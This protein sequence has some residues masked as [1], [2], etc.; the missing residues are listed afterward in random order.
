MAKDSSHKLHKK[1]P[2]P[3]SEGFQLERQQE[4]QQFRALILA[5]PNYFGNLKESTFQPV[6]TIRGSTFYEEIGCVGFQPQFNRLEAVIYVKQPSGYGGG[7][8]SDGTPEH[9]RFYLSYDGGA[10]WEDQG[11]SR[12]TAYDIPEGTEGRKRLEY[13]VSHEVHPPKK[14]CVFHNMVLARAILSWNLEPPPGDP[15]FEPVWGDIHNTHILVDPLKFVLFKDFLQATELE[16]SAQVLELID[17]LQELSLAES[18]PLEFRELRKLYQDKKVEPLRMAFTELHKLMSQP[19][20][21][22]TLEMPGVAEAFADLGLEIPAIAELWPTDGNTGYEE[23]ECV[24][25]YPEQDMLVGVLRIK[26]SYGYS[27]GPCTAGSTEYVTFWA[28]FNDNGTF[29][30]C[31]GTASV[32]VYDVDV[33]DAGLEYAVFLPVDL[34]PYLQPCQDGPKV[35]KIRAI[36]SWQVPPPCAQPNYVPAWGNREETLVHIRPGIAPAA[37]DFTPY[38]YS[39]CNRGVCTIDQVT[40]WASGDKPFGGTLHIAGEIPAAPALTVPDTLKYKVHVRPLTNLGTPI[41]PWQPLNNSFW[42]QITEGNGTSPAIGY[43][44]KQEIDT[45]G[46]YTYREY[47]SPVTGAWRRVISPNRLL[48][49]WRTTAAETGLWEITVEALDT[50]TNLVYTAGTTIC[51]VDG[52]TRQT[53]RVRLD[54]TKPVAEVAITGF[55]RGGG[56]PEDAVDCGTF[57]VGDVIHGTYTATDKHFRRLT[58]TVEP[59][60]AAGGATVNPPVRTYPDVPGAGEAGTWTLDTGGT[61]PNGPMDPCGYVVRLHVRDRTIVSCADYGWWAEDFVGFCLVKPE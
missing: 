38:L 15:D 60:D 7:V 35:V 54:Q 50:V 41:G 36:L 51:M 12:F 3:N 28:D 26:R 32:T 58:L 4:R 1:R 31:L 17:P 5:N 16:P 46:F 55:S 37:G 19:D 11:V 61:P 44:L 59:A 14:L 47:G 13:A 21:D 22:P 10:T 24:G 56:E 40:G 43:P 23:L 30:T 33:P 20:L 57:Q 18:K 6:T 49:Q 48:A 8:C 2:K 52:S 42:V 25:L 53:V 39:V 45:A 9:V 29:E 34:N 27:G